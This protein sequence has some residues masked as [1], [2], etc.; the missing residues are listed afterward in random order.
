MSEYDGLLSGLIN[1]PAER[2]MEG[3][4]V[5][6]F[7]AILENERRTDENGKQIDRV[8]QREKHRSEKFIN[9]ANKQ[10]ATIDKR[11]SISKDQKE[12]EALNKKRESL[13]GSIEKVNK[14]VES[15]VDNNRLVKKLRKDNAQINMTNQMYLS[16]LDGSSQYYATLARG[17]IAEIDKGAKDASS[18]TTLAMPSTGYIPGITGLQDLGVPMITPS[19]SAM[20]SNIVNQASNSLAV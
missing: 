16:F 17:I 9:K 3:Y 20:Y 10:I 4:A 7:S 14:A 5:R 11:L 1:I 8:R 12:I 13:Q 2:Y 18:K 19:S 15:V 6:N